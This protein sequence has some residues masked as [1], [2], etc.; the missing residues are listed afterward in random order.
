MD[1]TRLLPV[2]PGPWDLS[3]P[4]LPLHEPLP[5]RSSS[6]YVPPAPFHRPAST[7]HRF[8]KEAFLHRPLCG[9]LSTLILII[10]SQLLVYFF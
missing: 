3:L 6:G 4:A 9:I 5:E 8:L 2:T 7:E 1:H 10:C